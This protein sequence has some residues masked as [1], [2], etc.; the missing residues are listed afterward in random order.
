VNSLT[1][2]KLLQPGSPSLARLAAVA[3]QDGL[4]MPGL[5]AAIKPGLLPADWAS[6]SERAD[7]DKGAFG[8]V[9]AAAVLPEVK[10]AHCVIT[11]L[12]PRPDIS[13]LQVYAPAWP[14]SWYHGMPQNDDRYHWHAGDD[15]GHRYSISAHTSVAK[16]REAEFP[17]RLHPTVSP[18]A[19]ELEITW[20]AARRRPQSACSSTGGTTGGIQTCQTG[21]SSHDSFPARGCPLS[22]VAAVPWL[23][24]SGPSQRV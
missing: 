13:T 12:A 9:F 19:R 2:S 16:G 17:L 8:V 24:A 4:A 1:A 10:G 3:A 20:P 15:L 11:E 14:I 21:R 23:A 22:S 18:R 5:L 6:L 7:T